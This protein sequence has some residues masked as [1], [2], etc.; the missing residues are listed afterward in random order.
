MRPTVYYL[1]LLFGWCIAPDPLP[2]QD[3][4]PN[5]VWLTMEDNSVHYLR[6]YDPAGAPMPRLE[7]LA[8]RGLTFRNAYSQGPVCSVARS[9][10]ISGMYAPR[11]GAQYHRKERLVPLPEG[12]K[13]FPAYLREAGYYTANNSKTDYN[14]RTTPGTWDDSSPTADYRNRAPGQPFFYV[15]NFGETHEGQLHF[16]ESDVTTLDPTDDPNEV[17]VLPVH[18]DDAAFR[19]TRA[20]YH[21][22]HRLVDSLLGAELD[23]LEENG[24][25]DSTIIFVFGDHG[26]VLPGSK[27]YLYETGIHVP[28]VVYVPPAFRHRDLYRPGDRPREFAQFMDFGPTVLKLA[29]IPLPKTMDGRPFLG[30]GGGARSPAR[31]TVYSYADRFDAKADFVRAVRIGPY[32]YIRSYQPYLPDGLYNAYRYK[33][34]A[35][36]DWYDAFRA[37]ELDSLQARFFRPRP[38]EMLFNV[39]EDPFETTNLAARPDY[40]DTLRSL[41]GALREK[42][43]ALPDLSFIPEAVFLREGVNQ[44]T[45]YGQRNKYRIHSHLRTAALQMLPYAEGE[46]RIRSVLTSDDYL[47]RYWGWIV[48]SSW[49]KEASELLSLATAT[50]RKDTSLLVRLRATEFLGIVG[51]IDPRDAL[52]TLLRQSRDPYEATA[53]LNT[54]SLFR[55]R[56]PEWEWDLPEDILP[57]K[58]QSDE[59]FN[60]QNPDRLLPYVRGEGLIK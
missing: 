9:T 27:G 25:L 16:P 49:G 59:R 18:P 1:G 10:L 5:I 52:T 2:A 31:D 36:R 48:A 26:G 13:M 46:H 57:R 23:R 51:G 37:G 14:I 4:R 17:A 41:R 47:D 39:E 44:P 3:D 32:K 50:Y 22:R 34:W 8:R 55:F 56:H 60:L 45:E 58:W 38:P 53:V 42:A 43:I 20:R 29:G 40:A 24:L 33:M 11:I 19:Y 28:L 6:L 21:D 15:R 54:M 30:Q 7:E 35:Y 12:A